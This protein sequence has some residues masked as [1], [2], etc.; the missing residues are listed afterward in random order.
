MVLASP[1]ENTHVLQPGFPR[2]DCSSAWPQGNLSSS[3]VVFW[4]AALSVRD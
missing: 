2:Q 4:C 1:E 3:L